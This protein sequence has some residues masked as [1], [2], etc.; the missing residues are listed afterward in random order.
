MNNNDRAFVAIPPEQT[1]SDVND[2]EAHEGQEG[3]EGQ[4]NV[5]VEEKQNKHMWGEDPD[6]VGLHLT[7]SIDPGLYLSPDN[8]YTSPAVI[9]KDISNR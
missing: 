9:E 2:E 8:R 6:E 7:E 1:Y 3:Q 4:E 5:L